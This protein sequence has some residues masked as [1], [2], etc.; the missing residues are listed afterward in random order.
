MAVWGVPEK[1]LAQPRVPA[2]WACGLGWPVGQGITGG[3]PTSVHEL[4]SLKVCAKCRPRRASGRARLCR[5]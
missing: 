1:K 3:A 4:A 2:C 5:G